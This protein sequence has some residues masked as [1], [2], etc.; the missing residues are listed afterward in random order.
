MNKLFR[1]CKSLLMNK[2]FIHS[3]ANVQESLGH[4][5][6]LHHLH[7]L[8]NIKCVAPEL[9]F[10][11]R[12]R[13]H[14]GGTTTARLYIRSC[15]S[16]SGE[17]TIQKSRRRN[18]KHAVGFPSPI[19]V[20]AFRL[21]VNC[22]RSLFCIRSKHGS[23]MEGF[24]L[25]SIQPLPAAEL[26]H[27]HTTLWRGDLGRYLCSEIRR[28]R[29]CKFRCRKIALHTR[30]RHLLLSTE[31]NVVMKVLCHMMLQAPVCKVGEHDD[32]SSVL[33]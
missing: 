11:A 33:A 19:R 14:F 7:F 23:A 8:Q 2:L 29:L 22:F 15:I 1:S 3:W 6:S 32:V 16:Q 13:L 21:C 30:I 17:F 12:C 26:L 4:L 24:R 25:T 5:H 20:P 9:A 27:L 10:P 28:Q 31:D 18:V